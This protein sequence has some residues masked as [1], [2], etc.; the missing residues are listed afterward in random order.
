MNDAALLI[1]L[2][3][4]MRRI[5]AFELAAGELME[6]AL[7]PGS[8]HLSVGQEA[9]PAGVCALLRADDQITSTHRGHGHMLAKGGQIAPMIAELFGRQSGSCGGKGG[10][11]HISD[12]GIG[13]LG[14]NGVVG[15]GPP[16]A[17][18]AAFANRFKDTDRVTVAFFGDGASNQGSV[19]EAGNMAA[20]WK[21]PVIFVCENN[22]YAEF[23]PRAR[24]QKIADIATMADA[25]G[26]DSMVVDGMDVMAVYE[27]AR[28]AVEK[29]RKGGGPTFI[30]AKTYRFY[31]HI[32]F[33]GL[34]LKYRSADEVAEWQTRDPIEAVERR[35]AEAG[36]LSAE[37]AAAVGKAF[38]EEVA[39]AI[40]AARAAPPPDP[41]ALMQD[42]Y[43]NREAS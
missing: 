21:L 17:V 36:V 1:D 23:T 41:A 40:A 34:R 15:A 16:I 33:K 43:T 12:P 2:H 5:R 25:W 4:Q 19:H 37:Q 10:S 22:G 30:E 7:I 24:H 42:V 20:L 14:A 6:K 11:M 27:A 35:L 28:A 9:V 3:A 8:V 38:E 31:D 18:G 39:A 13:A 32:G 26:M 29:A